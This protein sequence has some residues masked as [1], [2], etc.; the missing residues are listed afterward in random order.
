MKRVHINV[1]GNR[2]DAVDNLLN[3]GLMFVGFFKP[4]LSGFETCVS[5]VDPAPNGYQEK[6]VGSIGDR[7]VIDHIRH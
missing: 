5:L 2:G 6:I 1:I 3:A 4:F 7:C